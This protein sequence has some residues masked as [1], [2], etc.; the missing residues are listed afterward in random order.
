MRIGRL[1]QIGLCVPGAFAVL[2]CLLGA[3]ACLAGDVPAGPL[4][5]PSS[6]VISR[7][8]MCKPE[9]RAVIGPIRVTA[10]HWGGAPYPGDSRGRRR[11]LEADIATV[12]GAGAAYVGSVNGR[13]FHCPGLEGEAVRRLDGTP[14]TH[15]GMNN[16][17][18]RCS[19]R[20]ATQEALLRAAAGCADLGMDGFILDSW[21]GEGGVL[22]FCEQCLR[23]YRDCLRRHR[24]DPRFASVA[25]TEPEAFDYDRYLR[26]RGFGPETPV[27]KLPCGPAFAEYR[28]DELIRRKRDL[29]RAARERAG[30]VRRPFR[31]TANVYSMPAATFAVHDL[32]D[33]LTVELPYFGSFDG[34]PPRGS[35]IAVYKKASMVGK[36]CVAQLGSHDTARALVGRDSTATLLKIWIAEAYAAGHLFDLAPREFA[37]Y[38]DGRELW[39]ELPIRQMLTY[40]AFFQAHPEVYTTTESCARTAILYSTA[41]AR[42]DTAEHEREY[43]A[44]CRLLHDAHRQ[45]DVLLAGDSRW[46]LPEPSLE[47]LSRY[48]CIV[49]LRPQ[50]LPTESAARLAEYAAT[51]RKVVLVGKCGWS[52]PGYK[53]LCRALIGRE[54]PPDGIPSFAPYRLGRDPALRRDLIAQ[55]GP[56]PFLTTNAPAETGILCGRA[57]GR[58]LVHLINY[59]YR[60]EA[61]RIRDATNIELRVRTPARHASLLSPDGASTTTPGLPV[62]RDRETIRVTVP[63]LHVYSV[64]VLE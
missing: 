59:D 45:F 50:A 17:V 62:T 16:A 46:S 25:G 63:C 23:F 37:G 19:L 55:L 14:L 20:P 57:G 24:D 38:R 18:Y 49:V 28:F 53:Q 10:I 39:L 52:G 6:G 60:E 48:E 51:G 15:P 30:R 61:D 35:S 3:H 7:P 34:P 27:H 1:M 2:A 12:H 56:D 33:Y 58:M 26:D 36:R 54:V 40:Y 22:C 64:I 29:F 4:W 11:Q 44:V 31:I 9:M 21:Q 8:A 5:P 42:S 43:N 32:L 41:A 13:G 47:R